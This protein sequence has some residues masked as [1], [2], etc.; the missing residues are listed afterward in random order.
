MREEVK[1]AEETLYCECCGLQNC[2]GRILC[3]TSQSQS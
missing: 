1:T 3:L 2:H